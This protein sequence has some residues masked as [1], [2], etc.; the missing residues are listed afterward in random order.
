MREP[1]RKHY[2]QALVHE[3]LYALNSA[4]DVLAAAYRAELDPNTFAECVDKF[5]LAWREVKTILNTLS[6]IHMDDV[7][8]RVI[9]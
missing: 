5:D 4:D 2:S 1:Q 9:K 6:E 8:E 7:T 3:V